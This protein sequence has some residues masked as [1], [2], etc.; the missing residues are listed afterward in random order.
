MTIQLI[1][2]LIILINK[3]FLDIQ[4]YINHYIELYYNIMGSKKFLK[5][6]Y[7]STFE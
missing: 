3:N 2:E 5:I 7:C 6:L 1:A 4:V